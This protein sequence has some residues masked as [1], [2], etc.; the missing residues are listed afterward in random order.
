MSPMS[1]IPPI[2]LRKKSN[3][4]KGMRNPWHML[5]MHMKAFPMKR[6]KRDRGAPVARVI[7]QVFTIIHSDFFSDISSTITV[8]G[9][10]ERLLQPSRRQAGQIVF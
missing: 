2:P 5:K 3:G 7:I 9:A 8:S 6:E 4:L 10:M 1:R